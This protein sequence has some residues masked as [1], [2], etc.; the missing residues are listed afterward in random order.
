M[1]QR[2]IIFETKFLFGS[3]FINLITNTISTHNLLIYHYYAQLFNYNKS[4]L[5]LC[6]YNAL[7]LDYLL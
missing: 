6:A 1:Y 4:A 3:F 2:K 7:L 5:S